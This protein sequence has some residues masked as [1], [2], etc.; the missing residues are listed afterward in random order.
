M[1]TDV[2]VV[3]AH[4]TYSRYILGRP[5]PTAPS[6]FLPVLPQPEFNYKIS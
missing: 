3:N 4:P 2:V 1:T 5:L 6:T